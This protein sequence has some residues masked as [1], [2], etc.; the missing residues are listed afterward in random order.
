M[1][2]EVTRPTLR[3]VVEILRWLKSVHVNTYLASLA[4]Y[5]CIIINTSP[6]RK[7]VY[8]YFPGFSGAGEVSD[9]YIYRNTCTSPPPEKP[10]KYLHTPIRRWRSI[11]THFS[12][13]GGVFRAYIHLSGAGEALSTPVKINPSLWKKSRLKIHVG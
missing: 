6:R 1:Q 3:A 4:P 5:K 8:K 9:K 2:L 12:V 10:R 11:F 13:A 7:G